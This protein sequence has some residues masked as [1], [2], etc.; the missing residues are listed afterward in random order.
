M[1][2][3]LNWLLM[4]IQMD[5]SA[6][7]MILVLLVLTQSRGMSLSKQFNSQNL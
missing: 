1:Q 5:I 3:G 4:N 6:E 2:H 7:T